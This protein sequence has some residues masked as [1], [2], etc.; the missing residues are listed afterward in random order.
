MLARFRDCCLPAYREWTPGDFIARLDT[1]AHTTLIAARY[2]EFAA[3][4]AF[5]DWR[6][7]YAE[8]GIRLDGDSVR[9]DTQARDTTLRDAI[10]TAWRAR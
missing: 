10:M 2:R 6:G 3:A 9:F 1:L 8:L 5:P 4:R 7:V